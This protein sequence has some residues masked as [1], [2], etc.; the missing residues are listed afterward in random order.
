MRTREE[1]EAN[2][3]KN[4]YKGYAKTD[5]ERYALLMEILLD[6]RDFLTPSK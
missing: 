3:F 4:K 1:I 6:I 5:D 2:Y